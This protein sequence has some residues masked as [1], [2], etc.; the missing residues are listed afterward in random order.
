MSNIQDMSPREIDELL[1]D[2]YKKQLT[3]QQRMEYVLDAARRVAYGRTRGLMT[4]EMAHETLK[5][6][7]ANENNFHYER[8]N[9][10]R[11]LDSLNENVEELSQLRAEEKPY[12]DEYKR[13]DGWSRFFLVDANNGHI[14]RNMNCSTC[15]KRGKMTQFS[16]LPSVSGKTEEEAVKEYGSRLCTVCYP[17]APVEWTNYWEVLEAQKQAESCPGSGTSQWVEG[18]TRFGY[19][20][21][22]GGRCSHCDT[23]VAPKSNTNRTMRKHKAA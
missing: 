16:W 8:Q 19:Y 7:A 4:V 1:A 13:R 20:S 22:N 12:Q 15:N 9:Y 23:W 10:A 21:G 6:A 14:H 2:N 11:D 5:N 17:S 3:V 18:T